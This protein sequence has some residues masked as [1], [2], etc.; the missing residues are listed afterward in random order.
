MFLGGYYTLKY[1]LATAQHNSSIFTCSPTGERCHSLYMPATT[2]SP[3]ISWG[4]LVVL[5]F[6]SKHELAQLVCT[7][8]TPLIA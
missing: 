8:A 4:L 3:P 1:G 5:W 7:P 6:S 2:I